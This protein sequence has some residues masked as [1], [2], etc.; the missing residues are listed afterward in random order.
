MY[1]LPADYKPAQ[2]PLNPWPKGGQTTDP[3][4]ADYDTNVVYI[5]LINNRDA[6]GNP[7]ATNCDLSKGPRAN[8]Q[9]V[10]L[11]TGLHPWRNQYHMGPFNWNLDAS[12]M[13]FFRVNER[14]IVRVNLDV[15]NV[16]NLQGLNA[17]AAD[18]IAS[19]GNSYGGSG[20]RP[21]QLQGTIRVE[22]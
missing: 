4:S 7:L 20:F 8:C 9:R 2:K 1:G 6:N 17:P 22:W 12:L 19:L 3:T 5:P 14:L 21:R 16:L 15:F 10:S 13:K 11:D 18:G